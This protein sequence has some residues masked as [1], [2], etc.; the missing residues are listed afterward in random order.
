MIH[1][2]KRF[3][4]SLVFCNARA[5][6]VSARSFLLHM[7]AKLFWSACVFFVIFPS[8]EVLERM[9][10]LAEEVTHVKAALPSSMSLLLAPGPAFPQ[11]LT[12]MHMKRPHLLT[13]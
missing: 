4:Q 11:T 10:P 8:L 3:V 13:K 1:W 6:D 9:G 7:N 5:H 2:D 12:A